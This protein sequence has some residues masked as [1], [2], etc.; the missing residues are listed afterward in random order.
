MRL[1]N[2]TTDPVE[3][4]QSGGGT[5][6]PDPVETECF[7][8]PNRVCQSGDLQADQQ[9]KEIGAVGTPPYKVQFAGLTH[10]PVVSQPFR[11]SQAVVTLN[12]DWTVTVTGN[13]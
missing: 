7:D 10:P 3:Y 5:P 6:L 4:E 2:G 9:G 11:D 12:S 8:G 13:G 1:N